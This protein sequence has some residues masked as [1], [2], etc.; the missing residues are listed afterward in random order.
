MKQQ[1]LSAVR[2]WETRWPTNRSRS[3]RNCQSSRRFRRTPSSVRCTW[4]LFYTWTVLGRNRTEGLQQISVVPDDVF[5]V[6][7][8]E[9]TDCSCTVWFAIVSKFDWTSHYLIVVLWTKTWLRVWLMAWLVHKRN[10][11]LQFRQTSMTA[12][13]AAVSAQK[14]WVLLHDSFL[15]HLAESGYY[16]ATQPRR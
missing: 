6:P 8:W 13:E 5:Q 11:Q 3:R 15:N 4:R 12:V 7:T 10:L 2:I 16:F 9:R 14:C 1:F